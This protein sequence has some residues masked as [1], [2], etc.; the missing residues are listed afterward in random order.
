M[1]RNTG[2]HG[3][4]AMSETYGNPY[5]S[6]P[7]LGKSQE[8]RARQRMNNDYGKSAANMEESR[9]GMYD[10]PLRTIRSPVP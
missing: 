3:R 8:V 1:K 4:H 10:S 2:K 5:F 6:R 7:L 9:K